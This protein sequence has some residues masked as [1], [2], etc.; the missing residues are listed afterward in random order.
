LEVAWAKRAVN[1][2]ETGVHYLILMLLWGC[3]KSE[4]ATYQWGEL[5]TRDERRVASHV[6]VDGDDEYGPYVFFHRTKNGRGHRL[7]PGPMA[8]EFLR[9]RQASAAEESARR[10]FGEKARKFAFPARSKLSKTGHYS[11]ATALLDALRDEAGIEKL[12][13]HDLRRSFEA[14]MLA[15]DVP[16]ACASA[17]STTRTRA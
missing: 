1:D 11:D 6:M 5:L 8:T 3:R 12:A 2:N 14:V 15:L 4:H 9:R 17:S 10:G 16:R 7:P 13:R